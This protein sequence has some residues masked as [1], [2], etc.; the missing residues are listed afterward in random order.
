MASRIIWSRSATVDKVRILNYWIKKTGSKTYARKLNDSLVEAV[1]LLK[2]F[3]NL[4]RNVP[5]TEYQFIVKDH[6]QIFYK[7]LKEKREIRILHVWDSRRNPDC[8]NLNE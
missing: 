7:H 6:Y 8:L 1:K 4:G 2:D 3:P 5:G